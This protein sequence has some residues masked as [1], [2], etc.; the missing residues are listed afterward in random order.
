MKIAIIE[1]EDEDAK[2]LEECLL[3]YAKENALII[4]TVRYIESKSFLEAYKPIYDVVFMDIV[5]PHM[6]GFKAAVQLRELDKNIL[7]VFVTNMKNYAIKGYEVSAFDFIVKPLTYKALAMKMQ[8][9]T[10]A[11]MEKEHKATI[12]LDMG[13]STKVLFINNI[14]FVEVKGHTLTYHTKDGEYSTR[15]SLTNIEK[16]LGNTFAR[17]HNSYLV[18]MAY[19]KDINRN[20][21]IIANQELAISR[22]RKKMF[23]QALANYLGKRI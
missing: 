17:C 14:Y 8:R 20:S 12:S 2:A 21:V 11:F 15:D 9:L 18:N 10:K 19:V 7:L 6:N 23:M 1:D 5:L 4:E 16:V 22:N 3:K 13:G